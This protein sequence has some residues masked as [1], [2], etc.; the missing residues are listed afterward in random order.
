MNRIKYSDLSALRF[1]LD[2]TLLSLGLP[3][4][5]YD[6]LHT[7]LSL[8]DDANNAIKN[9]QIVFPKNPAKRTKLLYSLQDI[10]ELSQILD[11]ISNWNQDAVR[12]KLKRYLKGTILPSEENKDNSFARNIGFELWLA[13]LFSKKG[14]QTL[15]STHNPD[16]TVVLT[17]KKYF[18]ECKRIY[19]EVGAK[20]AT[21]DA[22]EQLIKLNTRSEGIGVIAIS[23]S[24]VIPQ[25]DLMLLSKNEGKATAKIYNLIERFILQYQHY[26]KNIESRNIIGALIHFSCIGALIENNIL[27]YANFITVNNVH[28]NDPIFEAMAEDFK[29]LSPN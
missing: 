2:K 29:L 21:N 13:S 4:K 22:K 6:R 14:Y 8:I 12:E 24:K 11:S 1:R 26:W 17:D 3:V 23:I 5:Q 20:R 9:G 15:I 18:I 16:L 7:S 27:F 19:S 28:D 10:S 25:N